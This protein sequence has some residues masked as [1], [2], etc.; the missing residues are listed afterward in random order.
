MTTLI[1]GMCEADFSGYPD[2]RKDT[3]DTVMKSISMGMDKI[4]KLETP[5]MNVSKAGAWKLAHDLG[6][7]S[8]I[9]I[10]L[11]DTHTCYLGVRGQRY[12][13]G[14]GCNRCP[15]CDLR[16]KGWQHYTAGDFTS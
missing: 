11:E 5:L 10:I 14:Y 15:A 16:A 12:D 4:Y 13:W 8:L 9:D 1:G 6:G 3:L 7:Q 2:C